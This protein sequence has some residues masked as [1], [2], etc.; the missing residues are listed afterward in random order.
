MED[1]ARRFIWDFG[2][3]VIMRYRAPLD[4]QCPAV[5]DFMSSLLDDPMTKAMGAPVDDIVEGFEARHM[6]ACQR[7]QEYGTANIE[8]L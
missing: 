4:P 6:K 8:I 7:C 2:D 3:I 1:R 5:A